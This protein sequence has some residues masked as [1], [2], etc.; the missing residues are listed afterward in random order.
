MTIM[1]LNSIVQFVQDANT[2]YQEQT[3]QVSGEKNLYVGATDKGSSVT[4][5][6]SHSK[7]FMENDKDAENFLV[8]VGDDVE[9]VNGEA[10]AKI[11][12]AGSNTSIKSKGETKVYSQGNNVNINLGEGN[13]TVLM[14]GKGINLNAGNGNNNIRSG[15]FE[16][17]LEPGKFYMNVI[18]SAPIVVDNDILLAFDA[19]ADEAEE[20]N[21]EETDNSAGE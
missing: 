2:S 1:G 9:I 3:G 11:V 19:T 17:S 18:S 13:D 4:N 10:N 12:S 16:I 6:S 21:E 7:F 5:N 8:S 14:S 20:E 15:S